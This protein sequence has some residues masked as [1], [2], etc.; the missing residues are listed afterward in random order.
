MASDLIASAKS[1]FVQVDGIRTHYVED[2]DGAPLILLID[3]AWEHLGT[4]AGSAVSVHEVQSAILPPH[5]SRSA[6]RI[7]RFPVTS[8][9]PRSCRD[10]Q[11]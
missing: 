10:Q 8:R 11:G 3:G 9:R 4:S 2:G 6:G 5:R 1:R 7:S